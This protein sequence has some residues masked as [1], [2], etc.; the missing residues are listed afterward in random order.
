MEV[1]EQ[2]V[3]IREHTAASPV[4]WSVVEST[5]LLRPAFLRATQHTGEVIYDGAVLAQVTREALGCVGAS[6]ELMDKP[7]NFF[8]PQTFL[9]RDETGTATD[10]LRE[11]M[12]EEQWLAWVRGMFGR[13]FNMESA[14]FAG[15]T[16]FRNVRRDSQFVS[17]E[18]YSQDTARSNGLLWIRAPEHLRYKPALDHDLVAF[19]N[20][21]TCVYE[22][23]STVEI[24]II[25]KGPCDSQCEVFWHTKNIP[26]HKG[27][28]MPQSY[29]DQN[30]SFV[31]EQGQ[32]QA[33]EAPTPLVIT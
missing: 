10:E 28:V 15:C 23:F 33:L 31:L 25:R 12:N 9:G 3:E 16:V 5:K 4:F 13:E 19:G 22:G 14:A 7:D 18:R 21:E 8:V 2:G 20:V 6:Q 1:T 24:P 29:I 27:G 11:P 32:H 17:T 30:G 26:L